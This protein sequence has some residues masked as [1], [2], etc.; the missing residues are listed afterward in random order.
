MAYYRYFPFLLSNGSGPVTDT[1]VAD[2]TITVWQNGVLYTPIT[3]AITSPSIGVHLLAAQVNDPT[4]DYKAVVVSNVDGDT[5]VNQALIPVP[6]GDTDLTVTY[7]ADANP[8]RFP[9]LF[10]GATRDVM[11]SLRRRGSY[12]FWD[13]SS[14]TAGRVDAEYMDPVLGATPLLASPITLS[15]SH[16]LADWGAGLLAIPTTPLDLTETAGEY[17]ITVTLTFPSGDVTVL[18]A[19]VVARALPGQV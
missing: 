6:A 10:V 7:D 13:V 18:A 8:L 12:G 17:R 9:M 5:A 3:V 15:P 1:T 19:R 14:A 11:V 16:G 2:Y 4:A